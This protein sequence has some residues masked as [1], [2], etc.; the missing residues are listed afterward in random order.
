M[1][2]ENKTNPLVTIVGAGNWLISNDR[3]GPKILSRLQNNF[4]Q[5]VEIRT[6]G[7][8]SLGL[9]DCMNRQD[10]MMIID[11]CALGRETG[12]IEVRQI[13][14]DIIPYHDYPGLH[15]IGPL[16]TLKIAA[17]LFPEIM[18]KKILMVLI[19][20]TN[21]KESDEEEIGSKAINL[22]HKEV[23]SFLL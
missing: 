4:S 19:E 18:P 9:L 22:I 1:L 11:A 8:V 2:A 17:Q 13:D 3:I 16:E 14:P 21:L 6:I 20:T 10:L 5:E 23:T 15:Q 7:T 12:S